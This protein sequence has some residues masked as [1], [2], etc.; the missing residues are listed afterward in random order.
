[1]YFWCCCEYIT[2]QWLYA[3]SNVYF[4]I[5][6]CSIQT[7]TRVRNSTV[8]TIGLISSKAQHKMF[9]RYF[10]IIFLATQLKIEFV[11]FMRTRL[12][13]ASEIWIQVKSLASLQI[14]IFSLNMMFPYIFKD[15]T[16][17][18]RFSNFQIKRNTY[19][20]EGTI[21][22]AGYVLDPVLLSKLQ[23]FSRWNKIKWILNNWNICHVIR[24]LYQIFILEN[25]EHFKVTPCLTPLKLWH[26]FPEPINPS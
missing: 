16:Q 26:I 15:S 5:F 24:V 7:L 20:L 25:V 18:N 9:K 2:L 19:T 13:F 12:L 11:N 4:V 23:I 17:T 10:S 22:C 8:S 14:W 21:G 6:F 3:S 1:M